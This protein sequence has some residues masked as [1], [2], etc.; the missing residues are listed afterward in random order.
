MPLRLLILLLPVLGACWSPSSGIGPA[1][2]R[3]AAVHMDVSLDRALDAHER[4]QPDA[5][6]IAWGD[7]HR[8]WDEVIGPGLEAPIGRLEVLALELH[9]ARIRAE[10]DDPGGDPKP[11]VEAFRAALESPLKSLPAAAGTE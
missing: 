10:L 5:A 4:R 7:A 9:L 3:A 8:D 6:V 2:I 11:R 1:E